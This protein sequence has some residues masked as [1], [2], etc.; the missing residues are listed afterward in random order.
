MDADFNL[1]EKDILLVA[2]GDANSGF[3]TK[4]DPGATYRTDLIDRGETLMTQARIKY[5]AN[6]NLTPNKDLATLLVFEFEFINHSPKQSR[7]FKSADITVHFQNIKPESGTS[8]EVYKIAPSNQYT[9]SKTTRKREVSHTVSAGVQFGGAAVVTPEV[10]YEV[11]ITEEKITEHAIKI[12][13]SMYMTSP[14]NNRRNT[15]RWTLSENSHMKGGIPSL[16]RCAV[17]LKR[18]AGAVVRTNVRVETDMDFYTSARKF[19]GKER[20]DDVDPVDIDPDL[21]YPEDLSQDSVEINNLEKL[22][23]LKYAFFIKEGSVDA[24]RF[25]AIDPDGI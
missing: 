21:A 4:N 15:V 9:F 19:F 24:N 1:V 12:A 8:L 16:V 10:G 3:R 22:D 7:R 2:E 18:P 6:G 11:G 25:T 20:L 5:I 14:H 17:L 13:G 23:L